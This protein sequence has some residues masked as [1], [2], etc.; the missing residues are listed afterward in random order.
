MKIHRER[1]AER[2]RAILDAAQRRFA[3]FGISKVTMEE[4]AADVGLGKASVYYYFPT[5]VDIFR[6]VLEREERDYLAS[7]GAI[8]KLDIEP[9]KKLKL[10]AR[11]RL[12]LFRSFLNLGQFKADSWTAMKPAFQELFHAMEKEELRFLTRL[13]KEGVRKGVF[14]LEEPRRVAQLLLH[15]LHGLRLRVIRNSTTP[16]ELTAN[17]EELGQE[18]ERLFELLFAGLLRTRP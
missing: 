8:M 1:S 12:E 7:L 15:V 6:A 16:G 18:I 11:Q 5:K 9:A 17:Y 3:Q 2:E 13:L 10:F 14:S 4:I